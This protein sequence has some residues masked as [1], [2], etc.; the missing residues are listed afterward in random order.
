MLTTSFGPFQLIREIGAGSAAQVYEA[1]MGTR[2]VALKV[3]GP[4]KHL[5]DRGAILKLFRSEAATSRHL[6]HPNIVK[7]VD[8]GVIDDQP[9]I[10]MELFSHG[11]LEARLRAADVLSVKEV[12]ALLEPLSGALDYA[13][14]RGVLHRDVKPSNILFGDGGRPALSDFGVARFLPP[15][16]ESTKRGGGLDPPGT[17]DFLAPEVL[18]EAPHSVA[19]DIYSLGMTAYLALTGRLPTDGG[20]LFTR[21]RDRVAGKLISATQRNP[22]VSESVS[23][24]VERCLATHPGERFPSASDFARAFSL[25]A[26]GVRIQS[27]P[28]ATRAT[29]DTSKAKTP[30]LDYWRYVIVPVLVALIGATVAWCRG[31]G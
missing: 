27:T 5:D 21:A 11:S 22:N 4:G 20:T 12:A 3:F 13:H 17:T 2:S 8:A 19:S 23:A 26:A 14:G 15:R 16:D 10:A 24:V 6:D 25:A 28:S 30:W 18:E 1:L 31:T 7:I 9:F 29:E